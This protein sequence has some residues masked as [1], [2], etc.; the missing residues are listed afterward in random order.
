MM[1]SFL[2]WAFVSLTA[3]VILQ[4]NP[5]LGLGSAI[6]GGLALGLVQFAK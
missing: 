5:I 4:F 6:V 2:W 3:I 1:V